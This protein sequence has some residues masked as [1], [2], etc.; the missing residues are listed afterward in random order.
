MTKEECKSRLSDVIFW[1]MNR[2]TA[3]LDL[4][5]YQFIPR[6]LEYGCLDDW[7]LIRH[8]YGLDRI[9][10]VCKEVR[11]LDPICLTYLCTISNTNPEE[12]RCYHFKQSFPTLWNS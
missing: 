5:A 6:V 9:V 2:E 1:D 7:R 12:Y 3:D 8:Y 4:H 10:A 11:S